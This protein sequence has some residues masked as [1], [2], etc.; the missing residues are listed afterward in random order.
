M[1]YER[2]NSVWDAIEDTPAEAD[3]MRM[4]SS[5]MMA[6]K[7]HIARGGLAQAEA[8]KVLE[9]TQPNVSDLLRGRIGVLSLDTLV[10]M[11]AKVGFKVE[12]PPP[13]E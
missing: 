9:L 2:F 12:M 11:A 8:A 7:D 4:R 3:E 5:L 10:T 6:L 1:S 13:A